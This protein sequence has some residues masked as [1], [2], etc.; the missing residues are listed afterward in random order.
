MFE[1]QSDPNVGCEKPGHP[2][3]AVRVCTT[4]NWRFETHRRSRSVPF[5]CALLSSE[6]FDYLVEQLPNLRRIEG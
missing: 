1:D 6:D 4:E 5:D 3:N 2:A